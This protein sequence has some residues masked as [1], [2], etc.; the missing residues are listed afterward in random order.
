MIIQH[1]ISAMNSHRQLGLN[2]AGTSKNLEKL[3]S[4]YK[5][6][7]AG[8]DAAGL[9]ISEKMRGQIR[10]LAM[11]EQNANNGI[12]LIQTAEGGLNETHAILQRMRELA[13]QS[14]NGTY[15]DEVDR[16]NLDKEVQALKSEITRI[17]ESTHYNNIK[18]LDGSL[19]GGGSA[20]TTLTGGVIANY[21]S[22]TVTNSAAAALT[23]SELIEETITIDGATVKID[24]GSLSVDDKAALTKDWST[25]TDTTAA[26]AKKAAGILER[27]INSALDKSGLNAN[28]V[29]GM[30]S[31]TNG[32]TMTSASDGKSEFVFGTDSAALSTLFTQAA[33]DVVSATVS[34]PGAADMEGDFVMTIDGKDY[35]ITTATIASDGS[36]IHTVLKAS[37]DAVITA[38]NA[39]VPADQVLDEADFSVKL[40]SEGRLEI[41]NSS[42][43]A[44]GFKDLEG[45]SVA[46][47]LGI[48][49]QGKV[50]GGGLIFQIGANGGEDQRVSLSV[51][52]MSAQGIGVAGVSI[53]TREEANASI[54]VI[55]NAINQVSG[56]RADLGALQNRLEH[57]L[58]NLGVTKENLTA[59]ESSIR[60]VDMAKEMMEFTKNNILVQASQ[61]ML[62]QANQL[63]QGVLSLLR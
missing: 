27:T 16:E 30:A 1:N 21:K 13:V 38:Y 61:A 62:A 44:I 51:G 7:R 39:A 6:N 41:S 28:H 58:N 29:R 57:T 5:I 46:K 33:D 60:D 12:S 19:S 48:S 34:L 24:W 10:G 8:D 32:F 25:G 15:K 53:S 20:G 54:E 63:P 43:V 11:A 49:S 18:L 47:T 50:Q 56:T 42:S 26:D 9:A 22:A 52:D 31:G 35:A 4:G 45:E 37:I 40:N 14:S 55:D 59:A 17:S 2:N 36:D 3:S 23:D